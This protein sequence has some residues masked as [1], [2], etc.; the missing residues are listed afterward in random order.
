[1]SCSLNSLNR[2]Y[3]GDYI[4]EYSR[5]IM[6]GYYETYGFRKRRGASLASMLPFASNSPCDLILFAGFGHPRSP[7]MKFLAAKL[8]AGMGDIAGLPVSMV[9]EA[10][11]CI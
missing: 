10:L 9:G 4:G 3:L 6:G 1:M 2:G 8:G 11:V 5:V 7:Y